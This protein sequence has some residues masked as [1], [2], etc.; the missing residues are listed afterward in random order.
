VVIA[1]GSLAG[2]NPAGRFARIFRIPPFTRCGNPAT[3]LEI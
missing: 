2:S 3:H 1:G